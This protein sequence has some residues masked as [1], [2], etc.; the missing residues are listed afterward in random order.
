MER[1][2]MTYPAEGIRDWLLN[3]DLTHISNEVSFDPG[4]PNPN[5]L[6]SD[7]KFCSKPKYME[8]L[9]FIDA[10][11]IELT[12]N[13]EM[14]W[15]R[16]SFEF[17]L[18]MYNDK[19]I[20]YFAGGMNLE[21]AR[22]PLLIEDHGNKLAFIG[23]NYPGPPNVWATSTLSG[24]AAC[25]D[26]GWIKNEISRLS[27]EGYLVIVGVQHTEFYALTFTPKQ[28]SDFLPLIDAGAVIVSGSQAHYPNPFAFENGRFVHYGLGN[29][30][31]DQMD[32]YSVPGI[33]REFID[34]HIFYDGRH[35][36]TEVLTAYLEDF[37]RPRP[38]TSD[39]RS[40]FLSEVF[41]A[42]GW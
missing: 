2:G 32:S 35:I 4:C 37:S 38:M 29:L 22:V 16:A 36:S 19:R 31:F 14:D 10:D 3:A 6:Q 7:T 27:G 13:H 26:Y 41:A 25:E 42:S 1:N 20:Q 5:P 34:R 40:R 12:G 28:Q 18:S 21:E 11:V 23:C 15:G 8:L 39:E 33:Q 9:E 24:N 30:F 17:T